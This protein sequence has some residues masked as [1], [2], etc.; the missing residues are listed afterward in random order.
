MAELLSEIS[1]R[2]LSEWMAYERLEPFGEK[3]ADLRS[4]IV[5][6]TVANTARDEKKRRRPYTPEEFMPAF[7]AE[8][9]EEAIE[10]WQRQLQ[11]VEMLNAAFGGKDLRN[12]K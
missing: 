7:Q 5:A 1:S 3:R 9:E 2:E 10:P 12:A 11:M 4:A 6:S 8:D